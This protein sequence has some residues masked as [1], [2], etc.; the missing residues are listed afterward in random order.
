MLST[1][2]IKNVSDASHYYAA[3]DNYY[4]IEEGIAQSEWFGK[5]AIKLD[6]AGAIEPTQFTKLLKGTMP[7]GEIIGK[8]VD[9]QVIH[10][11][12]WDLTFSAPKSVSIM[13]LLAGDK[14]LIEAHNQAVKTALSEIE[15]GCSEVRIKSQES[16]SYLHTRNMI[17]ALFH[18]DLSRAEDPQLHTHSVVMNLTERLDGKWRSMASKMGRY[19]KDTQGEIHGFLERVRHNKRYFGKLYEAELAFQVQQL[20]YEIVTDEKTGVF[21]I[22][23]VC[24]EIID[25]FSKRRNRIEKH[26]ETQG[27]SG[28]KAAE[29]ATL[30]TRENK[31]QT[32][33]ELLLSKWLEGAKTFQFDGAALI[34][35]SEGRLLQKSDEL[36]M[37]PNES[38]I[39]IIQTV[40]DYISQFKSTFQPE[41][42][43]ADA[44][45]LAI[46]KGCNVKDLL[47]AVDILIEK[48]DLLSLEETC[49]RTFLMAKK[50][51]EDETSIKTL[52]NQN[53]SLKNDLFQNKDH[54]LKKFEKN[55]LQQEALS[56]LLSKDKFIL[57][58]G[59]YSKEFVSKEMIEIAKSE[60]L[61]LAVVSPNLITSKEFALSIKSHQSSF[62]GTIKSIFIDI[63][64]QYESTVQF[65]K[66]SDPKT[67]DILFIEHAHLL[68]TKEQAQLLAWGQDK[69]TKMIFFAEKNVLQSQKTGTDVNYLAQHGI[70]TVCLNETTDS[71]KFDVAKADLPALFNK[72]ASNVIEVAELDNR[73]YSMANHFARLDK[74]EGVYLVAHQRN[75]LRDLNFLAHEQL[76]EEGK[77]IKVFTVN[78]LIPQFI[79]EHRACL[80]TSYVVGDVI[81][82]NKNKLHA[83][84]QT[85]YL[86][87]AG[88][89]KKHNEVLLKLNNKKTIRW[90]PEAG[91]EV[92]KAQKQEWGIGERLRSLRSM[93]YANVSKGEEFTI[94][95]VRGTWVKLT[96]NKGR[97]IYID[98]SK[99]YQTHFDYGYAGTPHQLAHTK[100][101]HFIADLAAN[102]FTTNQRQFFQIVSQPEKVTLYTENAKALFE[103]LE[104]KSGNKLYAGEIVQSST[105][106]KKH[107][108][109]FYQILQQAIQKPGGNQT[110]LSQKAI[111]AV[112]YAIRHLAERNAGFNHKELFE[113]AITHALGKVNKSQVLD[114]VRAMEK[115]GIIVRG[116]GNNGVLWTTVDA[117]KLE[118]EIIALT[119]KDQGTLTPICSDAFAQQFLAK[120]DLK[121][122]QV[123]AIKAIV[124]S[125]DRVLAIQGRAGT[126][127]T[128]MM[129]NLSDVLAAQ[130]LYQESGYKLHGIAPTHKAVKE[131]KSRGIS[132]ETIDRFLLNMRNMTNENKD[133]FRK[134]VLIV[135]EASMVSNRKMRDVLVVA[136]QFNFRLVIPTGDSPHQLAA[137][138]AGKPHHLIQQILDQKVIRLEDIRRQKDPVLKEA[139]KAIYQMDVPKTFSI[140]GNSIIEIKDEIISKKNNDKNTLKIHQT[141]KEENL[142]YEKRVKTIAK[143]Y[144]DL[145]IKNEDVQI[146]TPSHEDRKAVNAEVRQNLIEQGLLKESHDAFTV[147]AAKDMS[148]VERTSAKNF[149]PG[150][151]V[152]FA[153]AVGKEIKAGDYFA[154]KEVDSKLNL[155]TLSKMGEKN[156]ERIWRIPT[157]SKRMNQKIEVFKKETRRLSVGDKIVWM[158]T[159]LRDYIHSSEFAK[160]T[161]IQ[162]DMITVAR[163]DRS[164]LT[165]NSKEQKSQHWDH[166]Y[167][168]TAYG[169]QGGT[170]STVL[171]LFE[172]YRKNLMNLK[173]F[174][175]TL[176]RPENTLR[177]YT[178]NK[179]KLQDQ[180]AANKGDKLSSLE[181]I[182]EYPKVKKQH[183]RLSKVIHSKHNLDG[184]PEPKYVYDIERLKISLNQNAEQLAVELLGQPKVRGSNFLKFGSHQGSLSITTKGEKAGWW[185]DFSDTNSK[186]RSMLSFIE[187][188][189]R[190][191]KKDAIEFAA[192]WLGMAPTV[193]EDSLKKPLA[194]IEKSSDHPLKEISDHQKK[195][196][197]KVK[198]IA[199]ES[200]LLP[201]TLAEIYLKKHRGIDSS[202]MK[203]SDDLRFHPSIYSSINKQK[204]PALVSLVRD[205]NHE[206][207]AAEAVYLDPKTGSKAAN[208][209]VSKQTFGPKKGGST[210]INLGDKTDTVILSEGTVTALSVAKAL[211][212]VS[213]KSVLGKQLL[214]VIDPETLPKNVV[215]CLDYD[216]KELKLDKTIRDAA[217]R[218]QA[219]Q[220]QVSFMVPS[221]T[222]SNKHDYN[223]VLTLKGESQIKA[224]FKNAIPYQK[225]YQIH[226]SESSLLKESVKIIQ[227]KS[228]QEEQ[229]MKQAMRDVHK[230][231]AYQLQSELKQR[232]TQL[233]RDI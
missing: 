207:I 184:H 209:N 178:D 170:Y 26:L 143:D 165:F 115:A 68:S 54:D 38:A 107:L 13:A 12:G 14:R 103:T 140:L 86:F 169:A 177:I 3:T 83:S 142:F 76:K 153:Q 6:L 67:P 116:M 215:I 180:I 31:T 110:M 40:I 24:P 112:D 10:R 1:S 202:N 159:D 96:R 221:L 90:K 48:G 124:Q 168:I 216:G 106:I 17:A 189:C 224:D 102:A 148:A 47:Q 218:L 219:H 154:I 161:A 181:V 175:V 208:L 133:T 158:R 25:Y 194:A 150:F 79:P 197:A 186:G 60:K 75:Q 117:I 214:S 84:S 229:T 167:A 134:T 125:S 179:A 232:T 196:Q 105:D 45:H 72:V 135:D 98:I 87:V 147:L 122:E 160:V 21:Q 50:T 129:A 188:Q 9:N 78:A 39:E 199:K 34:K 203:L 233:E 204:L 16:V 95:A 99:P 42:L 157:S 121:V 33:R 136:H 146:I 22:K 11:A 228:L 217:S 58:E 81:R 131:L 55:P 231:N 141:K 51:L 70:K 92:F 89:D 111:D 126:G 172:S 97:S 152:R 74:R 91:V 7:N 15:R 30:H 44:S 144:V 23:G 63:T 20:G 46:H 37:K 66:C 145:L 137:V 132:A 183:Q 109:Q 77:L 61:K 57:V 205:K 4:T 163:E 80:A 120:S 53:D 43:V 100:P 156:E 230:Q 227:Q 69:N 222:N 113:V 213:V 71:F 200:H 220:K 173:T 108:E 62:W 41:E 149:K 128:T 187:K 36:R 104:K 94:S 56:I 190:L 155:L 65:L 101:K 118:K 225:F 73:L 176:T 2:I 210:T 8:K 192:R 85:E 211:P 223:D 206:V 185:N 88:V 166:A 193:K 130:T 162:N 198:K 27:F 127:K 29:I 114:A 151:I 182:G 93:P 5:G 195:M 138:E 171:A 35:E 123:E 201:G 52:L 28:P 212:Q 82:F 64:I 119:Q 139:V 226:Q 32:D 59:S 174:L 19:D 164:Q 18:H 49:D 191:S